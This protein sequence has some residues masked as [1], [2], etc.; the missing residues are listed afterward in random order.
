MP[1]CVIGLALASSLA[2][3]ETPEPRNIGAPVARSHLAA[4][5]SAFVQYGAAQS[6]RTCEALGWVVHHSIAIACV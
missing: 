5:H 6:G 2:D 3:E 1:T 4:M